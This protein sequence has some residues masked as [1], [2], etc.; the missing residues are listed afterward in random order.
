MQLSRMFSMK[1]LLLAAMAVPMLAAPVF[2]QQEM[3]PT[4][5]DPWASKPA[6][7]AAQ[8]KPPA[9]SL[10]KVSAAAT[11]PKSKKAP[12]AQVARSDDK[13]TMTLAQK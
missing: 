3:D 8:P 2:A 7:Q 13:R 10:H 9:K 5:Y 11:Q 12:R 6:V 4:W 1:G